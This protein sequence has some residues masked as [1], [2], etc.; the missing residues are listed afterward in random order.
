M[1]RKTARRLIDKGSYDIARRMGM[2]ARL[3][4]EG[5]KKKARELAREVAIMTLAITVLSRV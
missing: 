5:N 2:I 4:S 1:T 3:T